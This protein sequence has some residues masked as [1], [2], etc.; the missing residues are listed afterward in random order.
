M[1]KC[2][3]TVMVAEC[4][5]ARRFKKKLYGEI[6]IWTFVCWTFYGDFVFWIAFMVLRVH[7]FSRAL[8]T[9]WHPAERYIVLGEAQKATVKHMVTFEQVS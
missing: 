4:C 9:T 5:L 6:L 2:I 1:K 7:L 3:Q 8:Y